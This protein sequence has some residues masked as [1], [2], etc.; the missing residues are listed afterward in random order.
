MRRFLVPLMLTGLLLLL[1]PDWPRAPSGGFRLEAAL[2]GL[3]LGGL[4]GSLA[5]VLNL[6]LRSPLS[7]RPRATA[8]LLFPLAGTLPGVADAHLLPTLYT[9]VVL[10]AFLLLLAG[11]R[12]FPKRRLWVN[13]AV[14]TLSLL[15]TSLL[16]LDFP[17]E[18]WLRL[19]LGEILALRGVTPGLLTA[20]M[21]ALLYW[22]EPWRPGIR[23]IS[24]AAACLGM[25][26]LT[27]LALITP[28]VNAFR[29][30]PEVAASP[31]PSHPLPH[32]LPAENSNPREALP[33][34]MPSNPEDALPMLRFIR[35][36]QVALSEPSLLR[37]FANA[38]HPPGEMLR[39]M[40]I[41]GLL[42]RDR[43]GFHASD[44]T[45]LIDLSETLR[46]EYL[47]WVER[48]REHLSVRAEDVDPGI[49]R[50]AVR[51][52][53]LIRVAPGDQRFRLAAPYR[54]PLDNGLSL[55]QILTVLDHGDTP[56]WTVESYAGF[57]ETDALTTAR[58]ELEGLAARG[59]LKPAHP[60][61]WNFKSLR[62]QPSAH[63]TSVYIQAGL[64]LAGLLLLLPVARGVK[65]TRPFT[66][67][68]G[69]WAFWQWGIHVLLFPAQPGPAAQAAL[70]LIL[71]P[72][73]LLLIGG[74][75]GSVSFEAKAD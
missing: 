6:L 59:F 33:A 38:P 57:W 45:F 8:L 11:E 17:R 56:R 40:R 42:P 43:H 21:L 51:E 73:S 63:T 20:L 55:R 46:P 5:L 18:F 2:N 22:R 71:V 72:A 67:W 74:M 58:V 41:H 69:G 14:F 12:L 49:F 52:R 54:A 62:L 1:W 65:R 48:F 3:A 75:M 29:T 27:C 15:A 10:P 66:L 34:S 35:E 61:P 9:R 28:A 24:R 60:S 19:E 25:A 53:V 50:E 32:Y 64:V 68:L 26:S 4:A 13:L 16:A 30:N 7:S 44:E 36:R 23:L 39:Q 31:F 70:G 37:L 47:P